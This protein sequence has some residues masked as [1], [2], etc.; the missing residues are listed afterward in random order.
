MHKLFDVKAMPSA[1]LALLKV[2]PG[3][4]NRFHTL[5]VGLIRSQ[6]E[7]SYFIISRPC[8]FLHQGIHPLMLKKSY[9]QDCRD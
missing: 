1:Y 9:S 7:N 4:D 5:I 8:S 6:K 2:E 3:F